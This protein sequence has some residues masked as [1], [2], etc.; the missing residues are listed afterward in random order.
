MDFP[1]NDLMDENACYQFLIDIFHPQGLHCPRCQTQEGL[2]IQNYYRKPILNYRCT[3]CRR[4]FNA[5][6]G[7][8]FQGTHWRPTQMV[9]VLRGF[10]PGV[11][12]AQL[13]RE[14]SCSRR[15]LLILDTNSKHKHNPIWIENPWRTIMS[16]PTK[17]IKTPEKKGSHTRTRRIRPGVGPT[18][19]RGTGRWKTTVLPWS[20]S[21]AE[22][23]G[24][25]GWRSWRI[26]IRRHWKHL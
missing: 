12:T 23:L 10:T 5:W 21:S 25:C 9:V 11:S 2:Q 26:R 17:C 4:V 14:L 1:I 15:H 20:G 18:R 16:K 24:R 13:A 19:S 7:T 8:L 3:Q 22:S 6:T